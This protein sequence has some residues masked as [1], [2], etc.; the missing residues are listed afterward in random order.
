MSQDELRRLA[1]RQ[2]ALEKRVEEMKDELS[3]IVR[4]HDHIRLK[5][6]PD[7]MQTLNIKSVTFEGI[8]RV[9][10]A[11]DVYASTREGKKLEGIQWLRDCGYDGMISEGYNASSLKALFRRMIEAGTPIPDDIFS[12][13][14]FVRASVVKAKA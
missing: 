5:L 3:E 12:V 10:L 13:T 4:E 9:Q 11:N 1:Q 2:V 8:G 7:L 14:P 6:I